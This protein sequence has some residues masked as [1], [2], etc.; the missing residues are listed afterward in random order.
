[1]AIEI[2]L[3]NSEKLAIIKVMVEISNHYQTRL[4]NSYKII[5]DI[6]SFLKISDG[7][8]M[9][10]SLSISDAIVIVKNLYTKSNGK[11]LINILL[12]DLISTSDFGVCKKAKRLE[13]RALCENWDYNKRFAKVDLLIEPFKKEWNFVFN[14]LGENILERFD[15]STYLLSL[16]TYSPFLRLGFNWNIIEERE[17]DSDKSHS[18]NIADSK[19]NL[20]REIKAGLYEELKAEMLREMTDEMRK[21]L[22]DKIREEIKNEL[23]SGMKNFTLDNF[24][25]TLYKD[26]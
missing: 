24:N 7:I 18:R 9:S 3:R 25:E 16:R 17:I 14:L 2:R 11:Y 26:L 8:S 1:M 12:K 4:T 5:Q 22:E 6:E 15:L 20:R 13:M 19:E 23:Q 21:A 10:N